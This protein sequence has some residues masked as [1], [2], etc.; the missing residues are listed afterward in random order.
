MKQFVIA[1]TLAG[2]LA[3]GVTALAQTPA[4]QPPPPAKPA[5]GATKTTPAGDTQTAEKPSK[6]RARRA[7]SGDNA[8]ASHTAPKQQPATA[9][10]PTAPGA[11][12]L[13]SVHIP[14]GLKADGKDLP[15][16]VYQVRLTADE[17]KPDAKGSTEK[18]ERWVEFVKGGKVAGREV[19]S[20]VPSTEKQLVQKD[21]PPAANGAKVETLKGGDYT[22]VWINRGGNY[23][24]IHLTKG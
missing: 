5:A 9:D 16:G 8:A 13:G 11:M 4:T 14:K 3:C 20:I 19:V 22:R 10:D 17:A 23:Y 24:L 6:P 2:A 1:G 18:L 21:T 12:A 15:A 7:A